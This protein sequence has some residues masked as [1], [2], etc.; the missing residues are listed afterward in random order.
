M[1]AKRIISRTVIE[2]QNKYPIESIQINGGSMIVRF[3]K[4]QSAMDMFKIIKQA[5]KGTRDSNKKLQLNVEIQTDP[6]TLFKKAKGTLHIWGYHRCLENALDFLQGKISPASYRKLQY[7]MS[8]RPSWSPARWP[9]D[10]QS[11]DYVIRGHNTEA[12]YFL[13]NYIDFNAS[14]RKSRP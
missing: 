9:S 13:R 7:A 8:K 4:K 1:S 2:P 3:R 5:C 10:K 6:I 12:H 11:P 14:P